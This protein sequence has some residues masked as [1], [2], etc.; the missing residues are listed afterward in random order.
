MRNIFLVFFL[1][2]FFIQLQGTDKMTETCWWS[3]CFVFIKTVKKLK[4]KTSLLLGLWDQIYEVANKTKTT[5]NIDKLII[6][7]HCDRNCYCMFF[8]LLFFWKY[9]LTIV[10]M[11]TLL[12]IIST[13]LALHLFKHR[14]GKDILKS[15]NKYN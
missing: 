14:Q 8:F 15:I 11:L 3:N 1:F 9:D 6:H 2:R 4:R 5:V 7:V 12:N 10:T 13:C